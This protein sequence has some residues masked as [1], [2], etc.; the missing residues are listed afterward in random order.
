VRLDGVPQHEDC[1]RRLAEKAKQ[2]P[3]TLNWTGFQILAGEMGSYFYGSQADGWASIVAREPN[4]EM[5]LRLLGEQEGSALLK[6]LN[7]SVTSMRYVVFRDRPELS[8]APDQAE[9][10]PPFVMRT[11]V[12]ARPGGQDAC[13]ELIRKV[14]ESVPKVDDPRRFTTLQT[15]IGDINEYSIVRSLNDPA[16]LDR[17]RTV[18][19]LLNDV[20]GTAEGG[21]ILRSGREAIESVQADLATYREDL[22]NA[23]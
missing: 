9:Q 6:Q 23:P 20:F 16:E 14:A 1:V 19:D 22:S 5:I 12:R 2:D 15:L 17:E 21:L 13:E 18:P 7:E 8:Y 10:V 3:D 4:T 11:R